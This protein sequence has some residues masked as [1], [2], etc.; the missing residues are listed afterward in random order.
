MRSFRGKS[1]HT[2]MLLCTAALAAPLWAGP[3]MAQSAEEEVAG[4][5]II[6]TAQRRN[7]KLEEVPM[8]VQVVTAATL[9]NSGI[10]SMRDMQ[11]VTS[12]FSLN[13]S[14]SY[15]QPADPRHH[16]DQCGIL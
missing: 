2:V 5:D 12:G 6:V 8:S 9:A 4:N 7:E 14:G 3:A 1:R 15:P 11:N 10:N 13:N 16:D